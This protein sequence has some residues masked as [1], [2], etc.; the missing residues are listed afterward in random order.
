MEPNTKN[1][2]NNPIKDSYRTVGFHRLLG[3]WYYNMLAILLGSI[4]FI[5]MFAVILPL[6]MK[7]PEIEGYSKI[8]YG[9]LGF[10]FG[11]F[12]LGSTRGQDATVAG[13]LND[14]LLRFVGEY[15]HINP[16]RA[17]KYVQVFVWFQMFTG[18]IQIALISAITLWWVPF[19]SVAHLGWFFLTYSLIQFPG[20]LQIFESIFKGFQQIHLFTIY[21]FLKDTVI[22][23]GTQISCILIGS[24]WG[25]SNPVIGEIMG[26]TIGYIISFWMNMI[27]SFILGAVLFKVKMKSYG[28]FV[29]DLFAVQFNKKI[30]IETFT[31][32]IK[33]WVGTLINQLAEFLVN[34]MFVVLIPNYGVY[35]GLISFAQQLA[36]LSSMSGVMV[37]NATPALAESYANKKPELFRNYVMNLMKYHGF[38]SSYLLIPLILFLP[39]ILGGIINMVKELEGY[40]P[41][42]QI[43]PM[44]MITETFFN[45]LDSLSG[46]LITSLNRP[47]AKVLLD[48]INIP[49]KL[50]SIFLLAKF[51]FTW[52]AIVLSIAIQRLI[53]IIIRFYYVQ[54]KIIKLHWNSFSFYW[55]SYIVPLIIAA[56][57]IPL[58]LLLRFLVLNP[59]IN[60]NI[61]LLSIGIGIIIFLFSLFLYPIFIYTPIYAALGGFDDYGI[62]LFEK[63]SD[64]SGP[65]QF[66]T[67]PMLWL[68]KKVSKHSKIHNLFPLPGTMLAEQERLELNQLGLEKKS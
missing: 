58:L 45:P 31:F 18:I 14:G 32:S 50:L 57:S 6:I 62:D 17:F 63:S 28:V 42:I 64:L 9:F 61:P 10:A 37:R 23:Y 4:F 68:I 2:P 40:L 7:Y 33:L 21:T 44:M 56:I 27:I 39:P 53:S 46:L 41:M 48:I 16:K 22:K 26:A 59:L 47:L 38:I 5:A 12:D 30:I 19:T 8:V 20:C 55:Q 15:E 3:G 66:I 60:L 34:I 1:L 67:K 65:S 52:Q 24:A 36:A 13:Q 29:K 35:L 11:F 51:G 25:R 43:L 54:K 49:V